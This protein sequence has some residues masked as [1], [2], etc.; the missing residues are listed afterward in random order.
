MATI[1]AAAAGGNWSAG[2]TWVGGIAPTAAD[3][4]LLTVTSGN[5]TIDGLTA[6]PN[7]CRSLN[8]TGYV[9]TLTQAGNRHLDIGDGTAGTSNVA[10]LLVNGM[11][12]V[13]D[14]AS[15]TSFVSTSVT[16]Q[17]VD[18][19]NKTA[20]GIRWTTGSYILARALAVGASSANIQGAA[21]STGGFGITG[22]SANFAMTSGS[23]DLGASVVNVD[24][25]NFTGGT[26]SNAGTSSLTHTGVQQFSGGGSTFYDVTV[27]GKCT[28]SIS[29]CTFHNLT[30]TPGTTGSTTFG[31]TT[32]AITVNNNLN[33]SPT[34]KHTISLSGNITVSGT[35]TLA[36][37]SAITGRLDVKSGTLGTARTITAAATS[38]MQHLNLRDITGAGA[39]A[40]NLASITGNSGDC[41]GNSGIT[42]TTA[43]DQYA[44]GVTGTATTWETSAIWATSSGG[45]GGTGRVPLPQDLAIFDANSGA[46]T[47]ITI[48]QDAIGGIQFNRG[49]M[50][51]AMPTTCNI[52]GSVTL[53]ASGALTGGAT[54]VFLMG[55]GSRTMDWSGAA[56]VAWLMR[57][58][59]ASGTYT[60]SAA[61][62]VSAGDWRIVSGTFATGNYNCNFNS[63]DLSGTT[64]RTVTLG[65]S[66]VTLSGTNGFTWDATTVTNLSLSAASSTITISTVSASVRNFAGGGLTYGTLSYTVNGSTGQLIISGSNTFNTINFTD[67]TNARTLSLTG[68]TTQTITGTLNVNGTSGKLMSIIRSSASVTT[69]SKTSGTY[70]SLDYVSLTNIA[71]DAGSPRKFAGANSS[72]GGG[73]TNWIFTAPVAW[74][75]TPS[76]A[77]TTDE[78]LM[79]ARVVRP[80]FATGV[81]QGLMMARVVR[82]GF[83][84]D[85]STALTAVGFNTFHTA[86]AFSGSGGMSGSG[87][88][89]IHS[90]LSSLSGLSG[91]A[92]RGSLQIAGSASALEGVGSFAGAGTSQTAGGGSLAGSGALAGVG[93][94]QIHSTP[95][96]SSAQSDMSGRGVTQ[97]RAALAELSGLST[98]AGIGMITILQP[99]EIMSAVSAMTGVGFLSITASP[100]S[101]GGESSMS[102]VGVHQIHGTAA[103]S[104]G[105]S[106]MNGSGTLQII[107]GAAISGS[108]S[109]AGTGHIDSVEQPPIRTGRIQTVHAG[110]V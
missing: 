58:D 98:M 15:I 50:Q 42:F 108:S 80:G 75:I 88:L 83:A 2:A 79:M 66:T 67:A 28:L 17:S 1:T 14:A 100:E 68:G 10:L 91:L 43:A 20:Q 49:S 24:R 60:L 106:T 21:L 62:T 40:W 55:R 77:S 82:P 72:N 26:I 87:F 12:Y 18:W 52:Y 109:F 54:G 47:K 57:L 84:M 59:C 102:G 86:A 36:G 65:T 73:N 81:E 104:F 37:S 45:T 93:R 4:V 69:I 64:A 96:A 41:G 94:L 61:H 95:A 101:A 9:G 99:P 70:I 8:C 85:S 5:V 34:V 33:I 19:A 31:T 16:Q 6:S 30:Y 105:P 74:T 110:R 32:S 63:F 7:L 46:G 53:T 90:S 11:T 39:A 78:G 89:A 27:T 29:G 76:F 56:S 22:S 13:P 92:S 44:V 51:I 107:V 103:M 38:G 97:V 71:T 3:D 48:G 25:I 35:L 23:V